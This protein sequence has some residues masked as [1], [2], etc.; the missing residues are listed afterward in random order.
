MFCLLLLCL[1]GSFFSCRYSLSIYSC[2][3]NRVE[4]SSQLPSAPESNRNYYNATSNQ[5]YNNPTQY[6]SYFSVYDDEAE[7]T[8][9]L[10]R[11]GKWFDELQHLIWF[12]LVFFSCPN[13]HFDF[14]R[15][16][17]FFLFCFLLSL[18]HS[19]LSTP[20]DRL[21][22][23][24][25]HVFA[26]SDY[27]AQYNNNRNPSQP[28]YV[29]T[30]Y[31]PSTTLTTQTQSTSTKSIPSPQPPQQTYISS[32]KTNYDQAPAHE[33]YNPEYDEALVAQVLSL[34]CSFFVSPL[35]EYPKS[36]YL[37]QIFALLLHFN[38]QE[39]QRITN[40][41]SKN[42]RRIY[43]N[44]TT[45]TQFLTIK[46]RFNSNFMLNDSFSLSP[47]HHFHFALTA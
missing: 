24:F 30:T 26:Y 36:H 45:H 46:Y 42:I 17:F 25:R 35:W 37:Q 6:N 20:C 28:K 16:M 23:F 2:V 15:L 39:M 5:E 44:T 1:F 47:L 34:F 3:P 32:S 29:Q 38:W 21:L 8:G 11:D 27:P 40:N 13:L 41:L 19:S 4:S 33:A 43:Q 14:H 10:Y 9:D 18:T 31:R 22:L 7:D 12:L